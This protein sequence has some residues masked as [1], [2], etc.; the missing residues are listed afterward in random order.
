MGLNENKLERFLKKKKKKKVFI[1]VRMESM[2]PEYYTY[3]KWG[4]C[5]LLKGSFYLAEAGLIIS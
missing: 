5:V 1:H 4:T 2:L 3:T